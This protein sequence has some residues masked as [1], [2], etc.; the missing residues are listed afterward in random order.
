MA[1]SWDPDHLGPAFACLGPCLGPRS[2]YKGQ[3][4]R[5][6][7]IWSK[8]RFTLNLLDIKLPPGAQ[9]W[10][11]LGAVDEDPSLR[12]AW[13]SGWL[14]CQTPLIC[15]FF[16]CECETRGIWQIH[17]MF[18]RYLV[19]KRADFKLNCFTLSENISGE[20]TADGEEF[21]GNYHTI[22]TFSSAAYYN[23]IHG[24]RIL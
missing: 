15:W 19:S 10:G 1:R 5:R 20:D 24:T 17:N 18:V 23:A 22:A 8:T 2:L 4:T 7:A 3:R 21:K 6:L 14:K 16:D 13:C 9:N 11:P 12:L